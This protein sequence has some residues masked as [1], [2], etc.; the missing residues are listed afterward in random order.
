MENISFSPTNVGQ[1][2]QIE[3]DV[4]GLYTQPTDLTV[5]PTATFADQADPFAITS[6][7]TPVVKID[8][9]SNCMAEF[10]LSL[11]SETDPQDYAGCSQRIVITDR[12]PDGR[13]Q[14]EEKLI[15]TQNIYGLVTGTT[16]PKI[17]WE[18]TGGGAGNIVKLAV[19]KAKLNAST[20]ANRNNAGFLDIP[21]TPY[22][23]DGTSEITLTYT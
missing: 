6:A 4:I 20:K 12:K 18:H 9:V 2:P 13:I 22:S 10:E 7:N 3:F 21:F 19:N 5:M 14:I 15:A 11:N 17:E 23:T 8:G 1:F 16:L